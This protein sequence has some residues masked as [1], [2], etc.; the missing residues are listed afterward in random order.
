MHRG[1]G[2]CR[3]IWFTI[4]YVSTI[5]SVACSAAVAYLSNLANPP[6]AWIGGLSLTAAII[7]ALMA[8]IKANKK[9]NAY[10][11]A[12]RILNCACVDFAIL[13]NAD[14]YLLSKALREAESVIGESDE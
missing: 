5:V 4:F 8:A 1:I 7:T 10:F 2:I 14:E 11:K 12:W 13:P 9:C 3:W 6:I